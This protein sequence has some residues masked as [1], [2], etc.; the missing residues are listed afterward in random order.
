[1]TESDILRELRN[2]ERRYA[3]LMH[4]A[5]ATKDPACEKI[6]RQ[7]AEDMG[8]AKWH[9]TH[10]PSPPLHPMPSDALMFGSA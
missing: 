4:A 5:E 9:E 3:E 10:L 8:L 7:H 1:M 6:I 2:A